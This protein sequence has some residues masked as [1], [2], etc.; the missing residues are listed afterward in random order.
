[1]KPKIRVKTQSKGWMEN[2]NNI[3]YDEQVA[4]A[5]RLKNRDV[6][7]AKVILDLANKRVVKNGWTG[8][9]DFDELFKYYLNGYPQYTA[10][11][12]AELDPDY[13]T[14]FNP[15]VPEQQPEAE[16]QSGTSVS[17]T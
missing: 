9:K 13:L 3:S 16:A 15:V 11:A 10:P 6:E 1:M 4:I 17:S 7:T 2:R 12:M 14:K 5:R 8:S